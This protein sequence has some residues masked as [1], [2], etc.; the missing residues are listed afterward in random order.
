MDKNNIPNGC[1][2]VSM[3]IKKQD[4]TYAVDNSSLLPS[5]KTD[6]T[7]NNL[8]SSQ[9]QA[10]NITSSSAGVTFFGNN[11]ANIFS[12]AEGQYTK[13]LGIASHA[14]GGNE[15]AA[16][17]EA[18]PY[19]EAQGK[20]SHAEGTHTAAVGKSSHAEGRG[21]IA[22]GESSHAAGDATTAVGKYSHAEG[23]GRII[24]NAVT[25]E[26]IVGESTKPYVY[27]YAAILSSVSV[28]SVLKVNINNADYY[29]RVKDIDTINTQISFESLTSDFPADDLP[30]VTATLIKGIAS[31]DGSHAEGAITTASG[32]SSHA[33]GGNTTASGSNSHAEGI[34]TTA[35]GT[36]SH[37]EGNK[38]T[39][40][41][42]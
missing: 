40:S 30:N 17:D 36:N 6:A 35:S 34:N 31:G 14:E 33:E 9:Y 12:T 3:F 11:S 23:L 28:G 21:T 4:E 18:Q 15:K 13:A 22:Y 29:L 10:D 19:N 32:K 1:D 16:G 27:K 8:L 37:A 25:F 24:D 39:A 41:G 2:Y 20:F 5:I 26:A 38:T 7:I 42:N